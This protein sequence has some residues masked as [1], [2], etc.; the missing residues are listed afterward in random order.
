MDE[1][2]LWKSKEF[3]ERW[4]VERNLCGEQRAVRR[5]SDAGAET[6]Y[7][8]CGVLPGGKEKADRLVCRRSE[9]DGDSKA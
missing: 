7:P 4:Q 9:P 8:E 6:V 2:A 1:E 5:V 3:L